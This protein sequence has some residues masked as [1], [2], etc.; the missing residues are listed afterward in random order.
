M[1]TNLFMANGQLIKRLIADRSLTDDRISEQKG[2]SPHTLRR[3]R[4]SQ[5]VQAESLQG[6]AAIP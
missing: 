2:P 6:L 5:F 3:M 4:Q 1:Q